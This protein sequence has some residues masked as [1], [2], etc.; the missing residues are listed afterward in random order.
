MGSSVTD[1]ESKDK[2]L[3]NLKRAMRALPDNQH[4]VLVMF[5]LENYSIRE[6]S[7]ILSIPAG[8][9][10]SRLFHAREQLKKIIN[11]EK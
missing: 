10:K 5:Y 1:T 3:E 7:E 9:V 8:T 2:I 11:H 6:M 4:L